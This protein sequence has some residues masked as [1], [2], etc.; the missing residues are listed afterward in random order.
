[1]ET[2]KNVFVKDLSMQEAFNVNGGWI[3][4]GHFWRDLLFIIRNAGKPLA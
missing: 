1:M 4:S 2:K 3:P